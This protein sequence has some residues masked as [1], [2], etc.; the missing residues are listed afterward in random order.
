MADYFSFAS[1]IPILDTKS[2]DSDEEL[3]MTDLTLEE[4]E[5]TAQFNNP[6]IESESLATAHVPAPEASRKLPRDVAPDEE[7]LI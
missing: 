2:S 3:N 5:P 7:E 4:E 6:N 1:E